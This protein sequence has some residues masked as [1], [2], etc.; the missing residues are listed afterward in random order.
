MIDEI[1][2]F[3][4]LWKDSSPWVLLHLNPEE[5]SELPRYLIANIETTEAL[6]IHDDDLYIK[7]QKMMLEKNVQIVFSLPLE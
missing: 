7:V 5:V 6:L 2:E 4:Y 3:N 1:E